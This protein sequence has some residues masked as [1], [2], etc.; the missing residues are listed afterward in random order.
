MEMSYDHIDDSNFKITKTKPQ[1][2]FHDWE[3]DLYNK[4]P[5]AD[6]RDYEDLYKQEK[7]TERLLYR[8][9]YMKY[10]KIFGYSVGDFVINRDDQLFHITCFDPDQNL[11][12]GKRLKKD[13]K[14]STREEYFDSMRLETSRQAT[15]EELDELGISIDMD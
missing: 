6:K 4:L 15:E 12:M 1:M 10:E 3:N 14:F 7:S 8:I 13:G 2:L 11:F 9:K 5:N